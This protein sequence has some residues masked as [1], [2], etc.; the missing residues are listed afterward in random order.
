[1]SKPI[2]QHVRQEA[3]RWYLE[4]QE[5]PISAAQK[6]AWSNW[7]NSA[8]SHKQAWQSVESFSTVFSQIPPQLTRASLDAPTS[9]KRRYA[10]KALCVLLF[11]GAMWQVQRSPLVQNRLTD[12]RTQKGEIIA[13]TLAG[14]SVVHLNSDTRLNTDFAHADE[15]ALVH[16]EIF[17][18]TAHK[19]TAK[20]SNLTVRV[21][22][23]LITPLGTKFQ[24]TNLSPEFSRISV[25]Q[26]KVALAPQ[27]S[28]QVL[29]L[30]AGE[31]GILTPSK[32]SLSGPAVSED[33][34]WMKGMLVV[35][36]WPLSKFLKTLMRHFPETFSTNDST[37]D[38]KISGSFR[39][40]NHHHIISILA[41]SHQLT[42]HYSRNWMGDEKI[43]L[44]K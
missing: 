9:Q 44:M 32:A 20:P 21:P 12:Y 17:I 38:V 25:Y 22:Q 5:P 6:Q 14:G 35:H 2:P 11:S 7:L 19:H 15:L 42:P 24:V 18:R 16:G 37:A 36:D 30:N 8:Q 43:M 13:R 33:L 1:M 34:A 23:G 26:G 27:N 40:D 31:S 3:I 4:L 39:L 41:A 10:L 29:I 28:S